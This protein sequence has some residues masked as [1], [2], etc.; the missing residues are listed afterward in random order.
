M[1]LSL[2]F[3]FA[4]LLAPALGEK[5]SYPP[6]RR[7]DTTDQLHGTTVPD[8]YRWLEDLNSAETSAWIKAQNEI[9]QS[10]LEATPGRDTLEKHLTQLWNVERYGIP[11][12]E[13]GRYFFTKTTDSKTSLSSTPPTH[14]TPSPRSSSI[15]IL[16]PAT[17]RSP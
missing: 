11:F 4:A 5:I 14:W 6:S 15:P 2:P 7:S 10:Y 8:P 12:R 16:S 9:S 13:G 1:R 3:L 17:A